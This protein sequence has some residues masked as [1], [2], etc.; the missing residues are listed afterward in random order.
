MM[1]LA[2]LPDPPWAILKATSWPVSAF[3]CLAKAGL[4]S[5]Y[6]SRVGSYDTLTMVTWSEARPAAARSKVHAARVIKGDLSMGLPIFDLVARSERRA[7][8]SRRTSNRSI[9]MMRESWTITDTDPERRPRKA[10]SRD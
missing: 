9:W 8:T 1:A 3:Q 10:F 6:S 4:N 7:Q 2:C 5:W